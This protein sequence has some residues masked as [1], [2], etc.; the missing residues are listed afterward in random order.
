M[1]DDD[2]YDSYDSY[3]QRLNNPLDLIYEEPKKLDLSGEDTATK[4][5]LYLGAGV[6]MA[7]F[8]FIWIT[9]VM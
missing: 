8:F 7:I 4:V 2:S 6:M 1:R 5:A 9:V 3:L